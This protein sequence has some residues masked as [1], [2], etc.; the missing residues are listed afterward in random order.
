MDLQSIM[1]THVHTIS[2]EESVASAATRMR[3]ADIGCLVVFDDVGV[4]GVITDRDLVI[5]CLSYGHDSAEC[6]VSEHMASPVITATPG[7]DMVDAAHIMTE[8]VIRRLPIIDRGQLVGLVSLS[9]IALAIDTAKQ[10][11][12]GTLHDVL[13]GMGASRS[14]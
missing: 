8:K 14:I 6:R 5:G 11:M 2:P 3:E 1:S 10:S 13:R 7:L 12:D 4:K 9:D